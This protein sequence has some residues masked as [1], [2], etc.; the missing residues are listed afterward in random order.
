[1]DARLKMAKREIQRV[2]EYDYL[3]INDDLQRAADLLRQ[4]AITARMK[5]SNNEVNDFVQ[6]WEDIEQ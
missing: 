1:M 4:I 2:S 5:T 6:K 3:I